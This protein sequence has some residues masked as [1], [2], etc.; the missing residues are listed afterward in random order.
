MKKEFYQ[1]DGK[2]PK[3]VKI[4]RP[5]ALTNTLC[6]IFKRMS[7]KR[8][9]WYMEKEKII[10]AR[11]FSFRK[12]RSTVNAISKLTTK[13]LDGFRRRRKQLHSSL[14]LRKPMIQSTEIKYLNN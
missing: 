9:V 2:D 8:L 10:D 5:V 14:T 6:K 12:Q 7:N 3:D 1:R 4:Y 13:I 11:Q